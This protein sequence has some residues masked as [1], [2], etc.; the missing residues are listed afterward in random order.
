MFDFLTRFPDIRR[1][2]ALSCQARQQKRPLWL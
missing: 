2:A 1:H